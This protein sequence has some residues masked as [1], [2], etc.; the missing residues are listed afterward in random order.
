MERRYAD[1]FGERAAKSPEV[2]EFAMGGGGATPNA[3]FKELFDDD[4]GSEDR[5]IGDADLLGAPLD[6]RPTSPASAVVRSPRSRS[7]INPTPPVARVVV[8]STSPVVTPSPVRDDRVAGE[9]R[10]GE[11]EYPGYDE[12]ETENEEAAGGF[13]DQQPQWQQPEQLPLASETLS[14][15]ADSGVDDTSDTRRR[16]DRIQAFLRRHRVQSSEDR[17]P[18]PSPA[19][20]RPPKSPSPRIPSRGGSAPNTPARSSPATSEYPT[21]GPSATPYEFR[22]SP[23]F[24]GE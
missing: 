2:D 14:A 22:L 6:L 10:A 21:P 11:Q 3:R 15:V 19:R 13:H 17:N 5:E 18:V 9:L 24:Q 12:D 7:P 20:Q 1:G 16:M 8:K 23:Q 4:S